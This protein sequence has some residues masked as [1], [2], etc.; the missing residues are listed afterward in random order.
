MFGAETLLMDRCESEAL[1]WDAARM[2]QRFKRYYESYAAGLRK[3]VPRQQ[4]GRH[5]HVGGK[6]PGLHAKGRRRPR[7]GRAGLC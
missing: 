1:F 4:G 6:E 3:P 5:L 7:F 2:V